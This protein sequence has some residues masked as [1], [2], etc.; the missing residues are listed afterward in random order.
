MVTDFVTVSPDRTRRRR[1][2]CCSTI[3][4]AL[5]VVDENGVLEGIITS[6]D[7]ID[8]IQEEATEDMYR[9]AGLGVRSGSSP[10]PDSA[11]RR[12]P[13]LSFNI[14]WAF[15]AR[16]IISLFEG[17]IR[18]RRRSPSSCRWSPDR[19]ATPVSRPRR[20]SCVRWR[21]ARCRRETCLRVLRKEMALGLI[22]GAVS[23][24]SWGSSPSLAGA[25]RAGA[26]RRRGDVAEHA[27]GVDRRRHPAE[28]AATNRLDPARSPASSRRCSRT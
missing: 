12:I 27:G 8:V 13:W 6:D 2:G 1:R 16:A 19:P 26:D 25:L 5:P 14:V 17:T 10:G 9:I 4:S 11:R 18:R 7:V 23:G 24:C 3:A 21:W 22:E 15:A 20:S 28:D